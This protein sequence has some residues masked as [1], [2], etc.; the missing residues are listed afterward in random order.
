L[1]LLLGWLGNGDSQVRAERMQQGLQMLPQLVRWRQ[2]QRGLQ[3]PALPDW[4]LSW[5]LSPQ[6]TRFVADALAELVRP[7]SVVLDILPGL[8]L[9]AWMAARAGAAAVYVLVGT[10]QHEAML[11]DLFERNDPQLLPRIRF[12]RLAAG[13]EIDRT[14]LDGCPIDV[15]L[16]DMAL[17]HLL[18][19]GVLAGAANWRERLG[20]AGT[21]CIPDA[22]QLRIR[23]VRGTRYPGPALPTRFGALDLGEMV[24]EGAATRI[25]TEPS[26]AAGAD[27][28]VEFILGERQRA[29]LLRF[30]PI[31]GATH[32]LVEQHL[33]F[34]GTG[35]TRTLQTYDLAVPFSPGFQAREPA[36]AEA[37]GNWPDPRATAYA[38]VVADDVSAHVAQYDP[39]GE[40]GDSGGAGARG[41]SSGADAGDR[42]TPV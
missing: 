13:T 28:I 3:M 14:L 33:L 27:Q 20:H 40:I 26:R 18:Y 32:L 42:A 30:A 12:L 1:N 39:P 34:R 29:S 4:Q 17:P 22:L 23:P 7:D 2:R 9:N 35:A 38:L 8:G 11:Q 5:T 6:P 37:D 24:R 21:R 31:G 36:T 19:S 10:A 25:A 41:E 15:L 16:A